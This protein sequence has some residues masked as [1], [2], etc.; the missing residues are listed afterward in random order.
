MSFDDADKWHAVDRAEVSRFTLIE[1][2]Y[3]GSLGQEDR[4]YKPH[5]SK[6]GHVW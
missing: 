4:I 3:M 6:N 1:E 5:F 2:H